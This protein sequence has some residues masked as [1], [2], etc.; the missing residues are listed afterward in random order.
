MSAPDGMI[1]SGKTRR[2]KT[3]IDLIPNKNNGV[4]ISLDGP[5]CYALGAVLAEVADNVGG[6]PINRLYDLLADLGYDDPT[7]IRAY[8]NED[9]GTLYVY[10]EGDE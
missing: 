8:V 5:A 6:T 10:D 1:D 9:E 4:T 2:E 7:V 3:M